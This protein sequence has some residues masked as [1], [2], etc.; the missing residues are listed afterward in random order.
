MAQNTMPSGL[1]P[2]SRF[3]WLWMLLIGIVLFV[4]LALLTIFTG[5]TNLYPTMIL[6]GN[7][8]VPLVFVTFLYEHQH[9]SNLTT[10]IIVKGFVIGGILGVLGAVLLETIAET[11]AFR[12][13]I[14]FTMHFLG[15]LIPGVI[16]E[17]CKIL[18][19]MWVARKLRPRTMMDGLLLGATVGMGFAALESTGYAFTEA[20][21]VAGQVPFS[22]DVVVSIIPTLMRGVLAIFGH[23]VW[24]A[25]LGAVLFQQSGPR[26]FRITLPVILAYLFVVLLHTTWDGSLFANEAATKLH[27][28]TA[29]YW[30]LG[31]VLVAIVGITA[32]IIL[33]R[34]AKR[35]RNYPQTSPMRGF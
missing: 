35:I 9:T 25:I 28:A 29:N 32:L 7:F 31:P 19:V 18:A 10:D 15:G 34:R 13:H 14:N 8:L 5:A 11:M 6:V 4:V 17:L 12:E 24:T 3:G 30:L 16:E 33:Y 20:L 1:I 27:H 23:G 2:G 22:V 21:S 26:H